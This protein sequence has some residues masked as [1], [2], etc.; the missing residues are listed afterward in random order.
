M[1][2]PAWRPGP[3]A[4]VWLRELVGHPDDRG[5]FSELWRASWT[6]PLDPGSQG[7]GPD[8]PS[9]APLMRQANLSRS[10]PRVLRGLHCHMR[11]A[12]MWVVVD[13]HPFVALVDVRPAVAG[14]G[15]PISA[16]IEATPG[17]VL[18][19][20]A[21]VAHGFYAR[22][23]VSLL[24]LVTNEHDGSDELGFAWDDP[25]AAVGWP[26]RSPILSPRDASAPSLAAL[27]EAL[28]GG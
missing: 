5:S 10:Q 22:D 12:D 16:A 27:L 8:A 4:G 23:A 13:G 11:Q 17:D 19:L 15:R 25:D 20:P 1:S 2:P 14:T 26:D 21:G 3:L 28:R 18:Y 9:S 7:G 24:Y 6:D